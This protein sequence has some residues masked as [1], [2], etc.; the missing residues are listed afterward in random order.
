MTGYRIQI[1]PTSELHRREI[2]LRVKQLAEF[3][4]AVGWPEQLYTGYDAILKYLNETLGVRQEHGNRITRSTLR[5][6]KKAANFPLFQPTRRIAQTT[7]M[8]VMA[9]LWAYRVYKATKPYKPNTRD[10]ADATAH[11]R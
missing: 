5:R 10:L 7:N 9:W 11:L 4:A 1:P 8:K 6:W 2:E 3:A